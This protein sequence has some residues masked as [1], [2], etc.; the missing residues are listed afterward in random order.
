MRWAWSAQ[1]SPEC[2]TLCILELMKHAG[3]FPDV[4]QHPV[5]LRAAAS[6]PDP[7]STEWCRFT[8][9]CLV[10][11]P[12]SFQKG[13]KAFGLEGT[14]APSILPALGRAAPS[15]AASAA[16]PGKRQLP[17]SFR[18]TPTPDG[19]SSGQHTHR[20]RWCEHRCGRG[21]A[22]PGRP[23][24]SDTA[25]AG[26]GWAGAGGTGGRGG[27]EDAGEARLHA[28]ERRLKP[29]RKGV[30]S[31]F[32]CRRGGDGTG[33][34]LLPPPPAALAAR[35]APL[36]ALPCAHLSPAFPRLPAFPARE[37]RHRGGRCRP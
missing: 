19:G 11:V 23:P 28:Q 32:L 27:A 36:R 6:G 14:L 10:R 37:R 24:G 15:P 8:Q 18:W 2:G 17:G 35:P 30:A 20:E 1:S 5:T 34:P 33:P 16:T 3:R 25:A 26:R 9:R 13:A 22:V 7:S 12:G 29:P 4:S 31:P 21:C